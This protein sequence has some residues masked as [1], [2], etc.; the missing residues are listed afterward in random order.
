M[1]VEALLADSAQYFVQRKDLS[2]PADVD[3]AQ[4]AFHEHKDF[5]ITSMLEGQDGLDWMQTPM[6]N[7]FKL[8]FPV[9]SLL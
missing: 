9:S 1:L 4:A 2:Y 6:L 7:Y 3:E 8:N 5:L